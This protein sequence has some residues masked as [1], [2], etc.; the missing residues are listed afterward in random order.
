MADDHEH[1]WLRH[2][3]RL[4]GTA[5]ASCAACGS[6]A[7]CASHTPAPDPEQADSALAALRALAAPAPAPDRPLPGEDAAVAAFLAAR[8]EASPEGAHGEGESASPRHPAVRSDAVTAPA[9][10]DDGMARETGHPH[11][12]GKPGRRW[13]RAGR[14]GGDGTRGNGAGPGGTGTGP[15]GR[16]ADRGGRRETRSLPRRRPAR[17][18]LVAALAAC[19]LSGVAVLSGVVTVPTPF[20]AAHRG[21]AA[22]DDRAGTVGGGGPHTARPRPQGSASDGPADGRAEGGRD[23]KDAGGHLL[24]SPHGPSP[25][26]R[27]TPRPGERPT[28]GPG[29]GADRG[30][31]TASPYQGDADGDLEQAVGLCRDYLTRGKW[32]EQADE[33]AVHALERR[34]GGPVGVR[35]YC[36]RLVHDHD[37][38][39]GDGNGNGNGGDEN[40]DDEEGEDEGDGGEHEDDRGSDEGGAH[41]AGDARD[42]RGGQG[43]HDDRDDRDDHGGQADR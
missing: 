10:D 21:P 22:V 17:A 2:D 29:T 11:P 8:R 6:C 37:R 23:G 5:L 35:A 3:D 4:D 20:T 26:G 41:R 31:G 13:A 14:A 39:A 36:T 30:E 12:A 9:P 43:S 25:S 19:A 40:E 7:S 24:P 32:R 1:D 42:G 18:V 34:A 27:G 16:I 38:I 28:A 15:R 33:D